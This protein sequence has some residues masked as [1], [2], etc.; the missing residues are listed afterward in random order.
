V[1]HDRLLGLRVLGLPCVLAQEMLMQ[2]QARTK[3]S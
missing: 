1:L 2:V 3:L